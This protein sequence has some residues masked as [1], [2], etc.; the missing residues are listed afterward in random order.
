MVI[1]KQ[2]FKMKNVV[3]TGI[4]SLMAITLSAQYS[5]QVP[6]NMSQGGSGDLAAVSGAIQT[7]LGPISEA[8]SKRENTY[9]AF[10]GSPYTSNEFQ[11][12]ALFYK[13]ELV[14]E[15]YYRYNSLNQEVEIKTT[16]SPDEGIRAL[17]RDKAISIIIKGRPMSFK[18]FIDKNDRTTNGYLVTLEDTGDYTLYKRYYATFKESL[19]APN[20]FS[21]DVPAKFTQYEEYY[22]EK[23]GANRVDYIKLNKGS[24]M[25]SVTGEKRNALKDY[26]RENE[27]NLR[28]ESDLIKAVEFL[29]S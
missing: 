24:L 16:N 1:F 22:L 28:K 27:I 21:K 23:A 26:L 5:G 17:G 11:K 15:I 18:T 29:N 20:S 10:R 4:L 8:D 3:M 6:T 2:N 19:K 25:K 9:D 12:T 14:G 7:L 13:D